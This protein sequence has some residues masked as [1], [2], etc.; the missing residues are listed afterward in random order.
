MKKEAGMQA[1]I[2]TYMQAGMDE[3]SD[4]QAEGGRQPGRGRDN[5]AGFQKAHRQ[6]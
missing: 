5:E 3:S 6:A 1:I 2:D 4:Q